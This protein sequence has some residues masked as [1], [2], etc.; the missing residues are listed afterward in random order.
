MEEE[1]KGK[2]MRSREAEKKRGGIFTC[3]MMVLIQLKDIKFD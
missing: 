1:A 2:R 3:A